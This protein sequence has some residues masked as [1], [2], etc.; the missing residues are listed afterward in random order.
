MIVF[1]ALF[2]YII[3]PSSLSS[4]SLHSF[5]P[6]CDFPFG[7]S[8]IHMPSDG[9]IHISSDSGISSSHS[10]IVSNSTFSIDVSYVLPFL[11][12]IFSYQLFDS[13]L[14]SLVSLGLF[15]LF[16]VPYS[17]PYFFLLTSGLFFYSFF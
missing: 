9:C 7:Y 17:I 2:L 6:V 1:S 10:S 15:F 4:S 3:S 13:S 16:S 8:H 12:G 14:S 5:H 11:P